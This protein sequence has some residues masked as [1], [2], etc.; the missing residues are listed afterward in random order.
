MG[1]GSGNGVDV[2]VSVAVGVGGLGVGEAG[3]GVVVGT[4]VAS[5]MGVAV[6]VFTGV[7]SPCLGISR[8]HPANAMSRIR[9]SALP[10]AG[11]KNSTPH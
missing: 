11:I 1:V 3:T 6:S 9:Y 8:T 2:G 4:E 5:E 10:R 7:G